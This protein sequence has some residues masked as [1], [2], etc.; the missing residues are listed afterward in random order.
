MARASPTIVATRNDASSRPLS[1]SIGGCLT[2]GLQF[3]AESDFSKRAG[4][5]GRSIVNRLDAAR[6]VREH[7]VDNRPIA[8]ASEA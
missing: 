2:P 1:A 7:Q 3:T 5:I 6:L 8:G 4:H